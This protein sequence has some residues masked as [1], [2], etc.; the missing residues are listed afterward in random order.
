MI[1]F[2]LKAANGSLH[3][4]KGQAG[5]SLMRAAL[6]AGV[7]G[8]RGIAADCGGCL[9]CGTCHVIL[10]DALLVGLSRPTQE[11]EAM[12]EFVATPRQN[13]SRLSC[14]LP[15]SEAFEGAV[16]LLPESQY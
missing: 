7:I 11:E 9:T 3:A 14:Q 13:G 16:V 1:S 12:L 4:V 2:S 5:V 10:E 8:P 15:L 6:D